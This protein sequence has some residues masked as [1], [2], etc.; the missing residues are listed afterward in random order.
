MRPEDVY[1]LTGVADPRISPDGAHVAYHV[2]SID[3]DTNQYRGAIWVAPLDGSEEPRQFTS[4]EK[5]DGSPRWSP[6]GRWLA[7][8]SNRG[9]DKAPAN[10]YVIPAEGGEARKLTDL[11]ESVESA[12]WSPESTRLVI[13]ARARAEGYDDGDERQGKP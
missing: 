8:T 5:R 7:F 1:E 13:T 9:D 11:K 12:E 4:G 10:L 6:D 2:W 3:K